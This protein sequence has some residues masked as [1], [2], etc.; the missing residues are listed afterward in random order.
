[1]PQA[2]PTPDQYPDFHFLFIAPHLGAEWFFDAARLYWDRYRPTVISGFDFL[3]F[4]PPDRSVIVTAVMLRDYAARAGVDLARIRPSAYFDAVVRETFEETQ[5]VLDQRA[6]LAQ[7]F[8]V[9]IREATLTPF[10]LDFAIP[11]PMLPLQDAGFVTATPSPQ[12]PPTADP[13]QPTPA[14]LQPTPGS[15]LGGG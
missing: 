9:P 3:S 8:G 6:Q 2:T 5:R 1:M 7:P 12:T 10:P 13:G 11:T 15:I 4:V 14:P